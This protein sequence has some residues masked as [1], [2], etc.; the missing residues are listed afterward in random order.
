MPLHSQLV[1]RLYHLTF[2]ISGRANILFKTDTIKTDPIEKQRNV[3]LLNTVTF[4]NGF[5]FFTEL[6]KFTGITATGTVE[7][8]EKLQTVPIQSVT[9]HFQRQDFQKWLKS[10]IGDEELAL[11]IDQIKAGFQDENLRKALS[12]TIQKRIAELQQHL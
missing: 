10:S 12:T 2:Y 4:E 5:Y 3:N 9:F 6:G 8:A 11:R 1:I 7:F